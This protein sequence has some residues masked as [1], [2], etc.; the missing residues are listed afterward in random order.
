MWSTKISPSQLVNVPGSELHAGTYTINT[1][2]TSTALNDGR[3]ASTS[4]NLRVLEP[5]DHPHMPL[6][7]ISPGLFMDTQHYVVN[8]DMVLQVNVLSS[9]GC[10]N[11]SFE[12]TAV[13]ITETASIDFSLSNA[14]TP[15]KGV[16][17]IPCTA[18]TW[19]GEMAVR[20]V[21]RP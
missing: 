20:N 15:T 13:T 7:Q 17:R 10:G 12:W 4:T 19:L 21:T 18:C 6:L 14:L 8:W 16:V 9:N 5:S 3:K 11:W 1:T 2:I